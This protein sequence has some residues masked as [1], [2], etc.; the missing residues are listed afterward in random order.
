MKRTSPSTNNSGVD[1]VPKSVLV[2]KADPY[3]IIMSIT[4]IS[5]VFIALILLYVIF[6]QVGNYHIKKSRERSL[7]SMS[8]S[9]KLK[10]TNVSAEVYAAIAAAL[11][12]TPGNEPTMLKYSITISRVTKNYSPGA[13]KFI[14]FEKHLKKNEKF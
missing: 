10:A 12:S 7:V 5:V 3:G 2:E 6:K 1:E 13:Q 4:A 14:P 8:D 9:D 11:H